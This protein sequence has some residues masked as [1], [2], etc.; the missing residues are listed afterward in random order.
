MAK[1][2]IRMHGRVYW[3]QD[4]DVFGGFVVEATDRLVV[5]WPDR[6]DPEAFTLVLA[7]TD[8]I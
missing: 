7:K 1:T 4:G 5:V 8:L 3:E 2:A 6:H